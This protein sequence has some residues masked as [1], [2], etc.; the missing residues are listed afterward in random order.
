MKHLLT[1]AALAGGLGVAANAY[2]AD[3][4]ADMHLATPTG[5]G[6]AIGTITISQVPSGAMLY[7][8]SLISTHAPSLAA[9]GT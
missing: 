9:Q 7:Q 2:A 4:H 3:L 5:P 8:D 6:A 1:V